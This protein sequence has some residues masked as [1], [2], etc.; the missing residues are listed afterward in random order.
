[1]KTFLASGYF[2][3]GGTSSPGESITFQHAGVLFRTFSW[4]F[5]AYP[6]DH[7]MVAENTAFTPISNNV[8]DSHTPRTA[9]VLRA[10]VEP[11]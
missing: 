6:T 8:F 3:L 4:S 1:M 11:R 9:A 5:H 7:R 2:A 10:R